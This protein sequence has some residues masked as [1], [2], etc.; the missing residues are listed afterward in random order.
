MNVLKRDEIDL[1][2]TRNEVFSKTPLGIHVD[3]D[4]ARNRAQ[5]KIYIGDTNYLGL[6][7]SKV[8]RLL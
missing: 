5:W 2:I 6:S 1:K 7:F 4:L 3:L 8:V